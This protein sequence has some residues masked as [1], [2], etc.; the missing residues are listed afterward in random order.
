ML[1]A[2]ATHL[3]CGEYRPR[4]MAWEG[5]RANMLRV[6]V[7]VTLPEEAQDMNV[8][9][10]EDLCLAAGKARG[11]KIL[12]GI[13]LLERRNPALSD[14]CLAS[15]DSFARR[16]RVSYRSCDEESCRCVIDFD[17]SDAF[18]AADHAE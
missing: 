17:I 9:S 11:A 1:L 7:T 3:T 13:A 14:R 6:H 5:I 4:H 18:N 12:S 2:A 16:G 15:F 8:P 10:P